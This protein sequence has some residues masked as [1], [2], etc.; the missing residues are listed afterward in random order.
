MGELS[1]FQFWPRSD[2]EIHGKGRGGRENGRL[3]M[4][5]YV[6]SR[7]ATL[8][9]LAIEDYT[10]TFPRAALERRGGGIRVEFFD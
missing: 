3:R 2:T 9:I 7:G 5:R 6:T 8:P 10:W 4:C 1:Q